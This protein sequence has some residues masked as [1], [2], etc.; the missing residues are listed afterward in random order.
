MKM[1]PAQRFNPAAW[2][3]VPLM[4][5][6]NRKR[7]PTRDFPAARTTSLVAAIEGGRESPLRFGVAVDQLH[8]FGPADWFDDAGMYSGL[9]Y[10][11]MGAV[12][13]FGGDRLAFVQVLLDPAASPFGAS[14]EFSPGSL[15][16]T[17]GGRPYAR[18]SPGMLE[19]DL[20]S[21]LGKP[22]HAETIG[23][24]R[25]IEYRAGHLSLDV[26]A[27]SSAGRVISISVSMVDRDA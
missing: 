25:L 16:L 13:R 15:E 10:Y 21:A 22:E 27:D 26:E 12:F 23:E 1:T 24:R 17:R 8:A 20:T 11:R 18:F 6:W 9:F 2:V 4:R 19:S 14:H 3:I 5:A 7:N